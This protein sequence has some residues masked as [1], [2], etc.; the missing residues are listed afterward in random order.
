VDIVNALS[1][2]PRDSRLAQ[3]ISP[4]LNNSASY[5]TQVKILATLNS[6]NWDCCQRYWDTMPFA[7][8]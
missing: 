7:C 5:F 8:R 1:A 2:D 4:W 6:G 3:S